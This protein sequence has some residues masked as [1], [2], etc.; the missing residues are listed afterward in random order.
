MEQNEHDKEQKHEAEAHGSLESDA[1]AAEAVSAPVKKDK[2]LPVSILIAAIVIGGS[3]VFATVYHP[4]A[5]QPATDGTGAQPGGAAQ[6]GNLAGT[7]ETAA[8]INTLG[9]RD[10]ILGDPNAPITLIEYG[11]YQC[12]FCSRYFTTLE[13]TIQQQYINTGKVKMVFRNFAFLGSES[14][15]SAEAAECAED[16]NQLWAYHDALYKAKAADFAKGNGEDDGFFTQAFLLQTAQN[17]H[18]NVSTFTSC[19]T[20]H[21]NQSLVAQEYQDAAKAGVNSTPSTFINGK[22]VVETDGSSAGADNALILKEL[23]DATAG[24]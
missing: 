11:D 16:Q 21:K 6:T 3:I 5:Q 4:A 13:P 8:Q 7:E 1:R 17:L 14:T 24:K 9:P 2:F 10:A 23:A 20:A 18:L 15:L 19:L 22:M 12:P